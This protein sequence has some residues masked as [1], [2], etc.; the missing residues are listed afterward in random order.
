MHTPL[1]QD[2]VLLLPGRDKP[3]ALAL[4]AYLQSPKA[5]AIVQSFGYAL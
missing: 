5:Q 4:L 3:A 2:M 1:R